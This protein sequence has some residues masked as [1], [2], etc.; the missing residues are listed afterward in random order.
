MSLVST[1][2][3]GPEE[4]SVSFGGMVIPPVIADGWPREKRGMV[5]SFATVERE[6]R[7]LKS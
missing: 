7:R 5:L 3:M 1:G 2:L 4:K 6:L